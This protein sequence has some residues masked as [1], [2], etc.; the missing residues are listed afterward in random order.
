MSASVSAHP[1]DRAGH[2]PPAAR[3]PP[4]AP[5]GAA[6]GSAR[7]AGRRSSAAARQIDVQRFT[8]RVFDTVSVTILLPLVGRPVRVRRLR[9]RDRR[10]HDRLSAGQAALALDRG[11]REGA[12]R[13][14]DGR[15]ADRCV[16]CL[17]GLI[18]LSRPGTTA[19]WPPR[20]RSWPWSSGSACYVSLFLALSL[21]TRRALVIGI[22]YMLV[23]EGALSVMLPGIANLS[24]RQYALGVRRRRST[25]SRSGSAP[26]RGHGVH[27]GDGP[28]GGGPG[29]G[30]LEA[31]ALRA[32]GRQRLRARTGRNMS[33]IVPTCRASPAALELRVPFDVTAGT[34]PLAQRQLGGPACATPAA[35]AGASRV[36]EH[37]ARHAPLAPVAARPVGRPRD[38][39]PVARLLATPR[40]RAEPG[41]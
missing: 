3:P 39:W 27:P 29:R 26:L 15:P 32:A 13:R 16:V 17:A 23:W 31:D 11:R 18:D 2:P 38:R 36:G 7:A 10:R 12:Q 5:A 33:S 37:S 1:G 6:R 34:L 14:G 19:S 22:G 8:R 40:R 41:C 25:S 20:R 35:F 28:G 4:H 30:H 9:G 24:I 21:F